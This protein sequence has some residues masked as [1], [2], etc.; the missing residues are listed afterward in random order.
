M[1]YFI[2]GFLCRCMTWIRGD[3]HYILDDT[4]FNLKAEC[5]DRMLSL[6]PVF[7]Y[8]LSLNQTM[9]KRPDR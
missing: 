2:S 4:T 5:I 1:C 7:I 6:C 8:Y 3:E 9:L